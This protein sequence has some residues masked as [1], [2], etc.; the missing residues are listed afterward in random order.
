MKHSA[1][2]FWFHE[3]VI[4]NILFLWWRF[5]SKVLRYWL[6]RRDWSGMGDGTEALKEGALQKAIDC[7]EFDPKQD[8]KFLLYT[9]FNPEEPQYLPIYDEVALRKSNFNATKPTRLMIH[10]W[11][12]NAT[13]MLG[14]LGRK[15][16]LQKRGV[17]CNL[18][19]LECR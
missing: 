6:A 3:S 18:S 12:D 19:R 16:Y 11:I 14:T 13:G 8:V 2:F 4:V 15:A 7:F 1:L 9:R 17:Q 5:F 10:G